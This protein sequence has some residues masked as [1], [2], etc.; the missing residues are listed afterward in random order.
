MG[1]WLHIGWEWVEVT[2]LV[3]DKQRMA[4]GRQIW[5]WVWVS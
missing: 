3:D 2:N 5:R 1:Y 4:A